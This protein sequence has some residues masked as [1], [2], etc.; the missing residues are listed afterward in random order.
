VIFALHASQIAMHEWLLATATGDIASDYRHFHRRV[1]SWRIQKHRC[2]GL[3]L[4]DSLA[5]SEEYVHR[6]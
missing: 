1:Q 5:R 4:G 2:T 6:N 3:G